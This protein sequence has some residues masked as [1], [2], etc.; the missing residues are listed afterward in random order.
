[1]SVSRTTQPDSSAS[2][3]PVGMPMGMLLE[4]MVNDAE[5]ISELKQFE[6]GEPRDQ[7]VLRA[8]KV[9]VLALK[10]ARGELDAETIRHEGKQLMTTLQGRLETHAQLLQ[11]TVDAQL[12]QYFDPESGRLHERLQRLLKQDGELER[13]LQKHIGEQDSELVRTLSAHLG[14]ES[15]LLRH[16]DPDD[17]KGLLSLL[18]QTVDEEL[19]QQRERIL[20]EFSLDHKDGALTRFIRE[21]TERQGELSGDLTKKIDLAV[22]QFSLDNDDSAL[23]RLVQNMKQAQKTISAEFSL[24]EDKSALSRLKRILES[25]QNSINSQLTLDDENS[26]LARLRKELTDILQEQQKTSREFQLEVTSTLHAMQVR[27]EEAARGTQ[28]GIEFEE[29]L[30]S[31]LEYDTKKTDD[32]ITATGSTTGRIKNCKVGDVTIEMGPESAAPGAMI[33]IEAKDKLKYQI[34]QAREEI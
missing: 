3:E 15:P 25:T 33:V 27:K 20:L 28:H 17:S 18:R 6:E 16:L 32:I 4:L 1:M 21:L 29:S 31:F 7:F 34:A 14:K 26:S 22:E 13:V 8:L 10:Q 19:N 12:K 23:S 5:V 2:H 11:N 30:L 24:D 9:G